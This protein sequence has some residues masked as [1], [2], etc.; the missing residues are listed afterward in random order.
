MVSR[1]RPDA[2]EEMI[3]RLMERVDRLENQAPGGATSVSEGST[4][5]IGEESLKVIGSQVVSGLLQVIGRLTVSGLGILKVDGLID[6]LGN[7]KVRDGG[8]VLVDGDAP[9]ILRVVGNRAEIAIGGARLTAVGDLGATLESSGNR[10][11]VN[12]AGAQVGNDEAGMTVLGGLTFLELPTVERSA[13]AGWIGQTIAGNLAFVSAASG[14][15]IGS[16]QFAWPFSLSLVSRE[17]GPG[18]EEYEDGVHKGIDFAVAGGTPIPAPADGT[19]IAKA[20]EE[21]RGNYLIISHGTQDGYELTTR[22]YHLQSPSP[23]GVG[24]TVVKG[25]TVGLVGTTGL[26]TGNH[27]HYET[28]RNGEHMNPRS[29]MSIYGE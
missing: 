16:G 14:G 27:L 4:E 19:V 18:Y 1:P 5:F 20:Y 24:D 12:A 21:E 25:E 7:L 13:I 29:F 3:Y 15:P 22:Y 11:T 10:I 17:Y 8:Y 2:P 9:I 26:S 28:R 6:L 23:L